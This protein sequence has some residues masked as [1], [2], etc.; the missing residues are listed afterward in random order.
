MVLVS[1]E[2]LQIPGELMLKSIKGVLVAHVKK[3]IGFSFNMNVWVIHTMFRYCCYCYWSEII[4]NT[5]I[6][7]NIEHIFITF[8]PTLLA[9]RQQGLL[10]GMLCAPAYY[11]PSL[12]APRS[13]ASCAVTH[14][15]HLIRADIIQ[16]THSM[17]SFVQKSGVPYVAQISLNEKINK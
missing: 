10:K 4:L 11:C 8:S 1:K 5:D 2:Q 12:S 3:T 14:F 16:V 6:W 13:S 9:G 17:F 15:A 7:Q